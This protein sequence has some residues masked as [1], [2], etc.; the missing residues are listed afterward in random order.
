MVKSTPDL[1]AQTSCDNTKVS[2]SK[3]CTGA[4]SYSQMLQEKWLPK[5]VFTLPWC[6]TVYKVSYKALYRLKQV[7]VTL[8]ILCKLAIYIQNWPE[9]CQ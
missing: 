7:H 8:Y 6:T 9:L 1:V 2:V 4:K 5:V 3:M